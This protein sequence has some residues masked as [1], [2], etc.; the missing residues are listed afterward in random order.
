[1]VLIAGG[2]ASRIKSRWQD[3]CD[4]DHGRTSVY[5]RQCQITNKVFIAVSGEKTFTSDSKKVTINF[6]EELR[7]KVTITIN[8]KIERGGSEG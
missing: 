5:S 3:L 1:M 4:G 7:Y 8:G 6:G 2:T